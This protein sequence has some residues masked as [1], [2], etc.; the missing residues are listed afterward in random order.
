MSHLMLRRSPSWSWF[1]WIGCPVLL[2]AGIVLFLALPQHLISRE[3][4]YQLLIALY[5]VSGVLG[6]AAW[7]A[8]GRRSGGPA[9]LLLLGFF[10]L[11]LVVA[12][13]A[14]LARDTDWGQLLKVL[15]F[16]PWYLIPARLTRRRDADAD[17]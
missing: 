5:V 16:I 17:D 2:A 7:L 14:S 6:C 3:M 15:A 8:T 12:D 10:S 9:W 4:T 11:Q 1:A 13:A